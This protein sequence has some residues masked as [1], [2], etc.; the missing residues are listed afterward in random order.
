[1][2]GRRVFS[3]CVSASYTLTV[4]RNDSASAIASSIASLVPEPIE[5]CAVC[6]ASPIST[7]LPYDQFSFQI[8]GKFRHADLLEING[9]P[10]SVSAKIS[11]QIACDCSMVLCSKPYACQVAASHSTRK[12]LIEGE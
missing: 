2:T 12:V 10:S 4:C 8:Q 5:K 6:R 1:M 7:M 3:K 11:S 9:W